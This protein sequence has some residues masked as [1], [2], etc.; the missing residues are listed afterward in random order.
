MRLYATTLILFSLT[1]L[2]IIDSAFAE[3]S[4]IVAPDAELK[5]LASGMAF[6]EGPAADAEGNVFFTDQPNDRIMKWSVEGKLTTF[7]SPC[8]RA[9]GMFFTAEGVLITCSDEKNELWAIQPNGSKEV[10]VREYEGKRLN[11]PNDAWIAP[12]GGI[13]FTDPFYKRSY[14]D[15]TEMEQDSQQVYYLP[16]PGQKLVRVTSDLV[17]PNGIIGTPDG[18]ILYVA[19]LGAGKTYR[20]RIQADG[21]LTDRSLFCDMG[22]DGMTIDANGNVYQTGKGV[23]IFNAN[24]DKIGHIEIPQGWTT[25]VC[26]GGPDRTTLF[27]TAGDSLYSIRTTTHGPNPPSK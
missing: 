16:R 11:G 20:Y 18:K 19:D 22:S 3:T 25:N 8:G 10:L 5:T 2:F 14:W 7:L 1:G 6:T 17:Q 4:V 21:S 26:F 9:N 23:T 12:G 13:Y 15:H 27:I 24:G